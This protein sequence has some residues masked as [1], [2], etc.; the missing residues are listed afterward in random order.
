MIKD[1]GNDFKKLLGDLE[2]SIN[3]IKIDGKNFKELLNIS[4]EIDYQSNIL[5]KRVSPDKLDDQLERGYLIDRS[6]E[7]IKLINKDIHTR[8]GVYCNL[9]QN[10]F[11]K[12]IS[13]V[14]IFIRDKKI[15]IN[16]YY[17][18]QHLNNFKYDCQ[19]ASLIMEN[20]ILDLNLDPGKITV[21]V[22][23]FHKEENNE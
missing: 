10:N 14:Q 5:D 3:V 17:R 23:S 8:R 7:C 11:G 6:D 19:T 1:Y 20:L 16:E 12:C 15:F 18:S 2:K 21:F 22:M 13:L 9:Y 4:Y